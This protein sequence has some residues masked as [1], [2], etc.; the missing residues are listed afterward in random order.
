M[1]VDHIPH[2]T[3]LDSNMIASD[4]GEIGDGVQLDVGIVASERILVALRRSPLVGSKLRIG[5]S[6]EIGRSL[7]F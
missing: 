2:K 1:P 5:R 7:K 6:R 3:A 4:A